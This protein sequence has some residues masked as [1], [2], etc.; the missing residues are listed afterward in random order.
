PDLEWMSVPEDQRI[1]AKR[2]QFCNWVQ[3]LEGE[4]DSSHLSFT[5]SR[6]ADHQPLAPDQELA[7]APGQRY[8]RRDTHPR[9]DVLDTDYGVVIAARRDAEPDTYYYRI[10]QFL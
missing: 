1:L 8:S 2:V 4:I 5:H 6:V 10:S 3:A 9:F 7:L